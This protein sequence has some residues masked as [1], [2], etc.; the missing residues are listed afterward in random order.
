MS[1]SVPSV[2]PANPSTLPDK[3][4]SPLDS[5]PGMS[6]QTPQHYPQL[7]LP[8]HVP[9]PTFMDVQ[10]VSQPNYTILSQAR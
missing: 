3:P 4:V 6:M 5:C 8:P 10:D 1:Q 2:R 7:L 9:A